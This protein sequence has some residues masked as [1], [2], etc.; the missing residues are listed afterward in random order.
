MAISPIIYLVLTKTSDCHGN[1]VNVF[2]MF[3]DIIR[4]IRSTFIVRRKDG[5]KKFIK[6]I[7][8]N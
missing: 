7:E 2:V 6:L 1:L 5:I 3:D 8:T 4:R